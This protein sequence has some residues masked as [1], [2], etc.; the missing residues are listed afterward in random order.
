MDRMKTR[1]IIA[2]TDRLSAAAQS[3]AKVDLIEELSENLY[4]R[5][6]DLVGNGAGEEEAYQLALEDL[7]DVD[8]LLAYLKSLGPDGELP[9]SQAAQE[10]DPAGDFVH[11]VEEIVRETISQTK[12]A[13]DQAKVIVRD[14][15]RKLKEKYPNGFQ[16]NV[17]IHF[18]DRDDDHGEHPLGEDQETEEPAGGKG[19]GG[20]S[21]SVGYDK[22]RGGFFCERGQSR[23]LAGTAFPAEEIR[24]VDISLTNGDV[25]IHLA[26]DDSAD[27][28]LAGDTDQLEIRLADTG[29]L[30][31]RQGKT[32]SSSFFFGRGLAS[33]DVELTLPRRLWE[34]VQITTVN[35]DITVDSGLETRE[36]SVK[37][38]SGDLEASDLRCQRLNFK[39]V[40]GDLRADGAV[41]ELH[42][43]SLSGDIDLAGQ[44]GSLWANTASGDIQFA[45]AV[46]SAQA[47][48][49]SGDVIMTCDPLPEK[50]ELTSKSGDCELS[51][52]E[53]VGFSLQ[54]SVVTGEMESEFDLTGA[55][56]TKN[57]GAIYLDGGESALSLSS[58]SGDIAL[59]RA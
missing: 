7:G 15:A 58:V 26:E 50:A 24:A 33:A 51:V 37:T 54:Y 14:V 42:A 53:G 45:G 9:D 10:K 3:A 23:P 38:T 19:H 32:A 34:A 13:V 41:E 12:D 22:N 18:N 27:V 20:W 46:Q 30:L 6:L 29:A 57:G 49:A 4:Q 39:A 25:A 11:S 31:V 44:V 35:G 56:G 1:F 16:G 8:E 52:P 48:S 59:R 40:S 21:F 43:E 2:V 5:Y 17:D 36:L 55:V 47:S 28:E